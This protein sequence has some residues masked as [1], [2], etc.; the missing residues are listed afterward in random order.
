MIGI[1]KSL[2]HMAWST[3]KFLAALHEHPETIYSLKAAEGEWNVGT[4][5]THLAGSAEWYRY[6]L[7]GTFWTDLE[8]VANH[9]ELENLRNYLQELDDVLIAQAQSPDEIVNYRGEHGPAQVHRSTILAQAVMHA[10]EH[11]GQIA[12]I[13]KT[14]GFHADLDVID[15][16]AFTGE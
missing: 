11:K 13:L 7:T 8:P 10:A 4:L 12:T 16:W 2:E 6:I 9:Q 14:N 15:V 1:Q 3:Q 5:L